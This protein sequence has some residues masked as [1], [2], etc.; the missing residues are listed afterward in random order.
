MA[1]VQVSQITHRKGL[2]I[3]LPQLAGAELGWSID[4]RQLFIGNGTLDEGAPVIGNTEI[5]TEFSDILA[6]NTTYTYKGAAAGYTVQTGATAGTPVTQNLQSWFDQWA[7]IIDFGAVGDGTTDCTDAINRALYQL[8][9]RDTNP[10]IRRALF[11]P[12]GVYKISESIIIPPYATLYGEGANNSIIKLVTTSGETSAN[13]Y[14]ARTGDSLQQTGTDIGNNS[15]I[16]PQYVT[17]LNIGFASSNSYS[18]IFLVDRASNCRFQNVTFTGPFATGDL[19]T[20][21]NDV[22]GVRF[23]S[24]AS[25]ICNEIIFDSCVFTGTTFAIATEE[26]IKG[27]TVQNSKLDTLYQGIVLGITAPILGGPTGVRV[28]HNMF[29][30]TYAEGIKLGNVSLN[31]TGYNIFYD[32]GNHFGGVTSPQTAIIDFGGNNNVSVGDMFQRADAY[33][34]TYPRI[35]LNNTVSVGT[36]NGVM[37]QQGT[38]TRVS[39]KLFTLVDNASN[40]VI[41]TIS[42]G[43]YKSWAIDYAITRDTTV[44]TGRFIIAALGTVSYDDNYTENSSTGITLSATIS[45]TDVSWKYTATSTG[46]NG[47]L[48]Y[49]ITHLL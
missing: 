5:L 27:I 18:D 41:E 8:Y 1:I 32:V 21:T 23:D 46:F 44:R 14:V 30:N 35:Q 29:D 20:N 13:S 38:F 45:G 17:C 16:T 49:S 34:T 48:S 25:L 43:S 15:A 24:S 2:Q 42:T 33:A 7:T 47:T 31:A 6:F 10:L 22:A 36:T 3:N 28:M 19:T 4:T 40:Q 12:A 37:T 26:Q 11:F 39:G 9:C